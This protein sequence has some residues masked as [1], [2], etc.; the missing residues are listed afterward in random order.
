MKSAR[1]LA[2]EWWRSLSTANQKEALEKWKSIT[3]DYRK[4][5]TWELI[6]MSSSTIEFIWKELNNIN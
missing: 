2:L 6:S 1:S 3:N 5:W 4:G